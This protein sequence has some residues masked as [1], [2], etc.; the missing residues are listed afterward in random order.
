MSKLVHRIG[1]PG[2]VLAPTGLQVGMRI[3]A[4]WTWGF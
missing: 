1:P 4:E 3:K 2:L